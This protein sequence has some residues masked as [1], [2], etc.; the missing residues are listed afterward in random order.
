MKV[1]FLQDVK[2]QGKKGE[3]KEV[4]EGYAINF[5][6]KKGLAKEA[7]ASNINMLSVQKANAQRKAEEQLK[8][9]QDT[10]K[11]LA[12]LQVVV[13]TKVGEGGRVFGSITSKQISDSMVPLGYTI[14][15]RKIHLPEPIKSLGTSV[16][17]IRLHPEVVAELRVHVQAE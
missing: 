2:G 4:A 14:D 3:I 5:L 10:A 17:Q 9:A 1:V 13:K 12:D 8:D 7:T 15:K 6:I 16:V 11:R